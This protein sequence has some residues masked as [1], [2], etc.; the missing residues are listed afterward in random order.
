MGQ[1]AV[2]GVA[3]SGGEGGVA[4]FQ[5][6][7]RAQVGPGAAGAQRLGVAVDAGDVFAGVDGRVVAG[8][9]PGEPAGVGGDLP[10][11][12][13]VRG[14]GCQPACGFG[15]GGPGQPLVLMLVGHGQQVFPAGESLFGFHLGA[16]PAAAG[17]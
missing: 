4:A 5:R 9:Q 13:G 3:V 2:E 15:G 7:A 6:A 17:S 16:E 12:A 1:L 14:E 11:E 8:H 10:G